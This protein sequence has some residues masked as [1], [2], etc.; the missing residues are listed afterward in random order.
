LPLFHAP[1]LSALQSKTVVQKG[2][3]V[4]STLSPY[5]GIGT[6]QTLHRSKIY[7]TMYN[8]YIPQL[9]KCF[10][11][12][13][14]PLPPSPSIVLKLSSAEKITPSTPIAMFDGK[15]IST[16]TFEQAKEEISKRD[17]SKF[18]FVDDPDGRLR[19]CAQR[20]VRAAA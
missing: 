6:V 9:R 17:S 4:Y 8:E 2:D 7:I 3:I 13:S 15:S 16:L 18:I 19:K 5:Y 11:P 1:K 14:K 10:I 20:L 12:R